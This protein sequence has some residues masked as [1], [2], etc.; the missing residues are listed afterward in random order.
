MQTHYLF[1]VLRLI[2]GAKEAKERLNDLGKRL[3]LFGVA[4]LFSVNFLQSSV[5]GAVSAWAILICMIIAH[6]F[7]FLRETGQKYHNICLLIYYS[8]L[9]VWFGCSFFYFIY[10]ALN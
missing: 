2:K 4:C 8:I 1:Q 3:F 7:V 6:C 9:M 10:D 5:I